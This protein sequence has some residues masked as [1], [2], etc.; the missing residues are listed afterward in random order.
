MAKQIK[1]A[2]Q[3]RAG[4]GRS[5][6]T[7]LKMQGLV[8][9]VVYG[10]KQ[11]PEHLQLSAREIDTVLSHATGEHFLVELEVGGGVA[12]RLALVQE[13]QHHPVTRKVLHVDFHAVA[14]D[15]LLHAAIPVETTG[16]AAGVK[17]GGGL[18]EIQL[19]ALEVEC[20][21]KDLPD[22]IRLDVSALQIGDA[23]HV[24]DV[25]LP[26]GVTARADGDLTV[27]RVAPP[28]VVVEVAPAAVVAAAA[29][30]QP[31]VIKE[32]KAEETK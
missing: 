17:T 26:E 22:V 12:N 7:K 4:L 25:Q 15:E 27:V 31:E 32:K 9:A 19:H 13:V 11:A 18:L 10:A 14:A 28:T 5:A 23:I 8:P 21:P 2:A 20:L 29:P 6:V 24:R 1:L 16:E 3:P 30:G